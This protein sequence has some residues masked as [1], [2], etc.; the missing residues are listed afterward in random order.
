MLRRLTFPTVVLALALAAPAFAL[1]G[2]Q[3]GP[4]REYLVGFHEMPDAQVGDAYLGGRVVDLDAPLRFLVIETRDAAVFEARARLD[5]NVRYVEANERILGTFL[6]PNDPGYSN[7]GHWGTKKILAQNAWDRTLGATT[8][9]VAVIDSGLLATHEEF[10]G[11]SRVLAGWDTIDEDATP[12]DT[13][14]HGTHVAGTIGATINNNKGIAGLAQVTLYPIRGLTAAL[15]GI[16]CSGSPANLAQGLRRAGDQGMHFSSNSWGGGGSSAITDAINYAHGK[17]VIQVAAAGNS[18]SCTNCVSEPWKANAAKIIVVSSTTS[19]DGFSSFSSQGPEVDVS[20]PGSGIYSSTTGS[21][22]AYT[23]MSGTSMATP[24]VTGVAALVKT[25][26][27][28]WGYTEIDN[29]LKTTAVDLG[30]AGKDDRFGYG[31]INADAATSSAGANDPPTAA[32]THSLSGFTVSVNGASSSDPDGTISSYSWNWGDGTTAGTGSSSSHTYATHGTYTITLTV[33][34]NGGATDTE[35]KTI[36]IADPSDPDATAYTLTNGQTHSNATSGAGSEKH[37]KLQ[38]PT[39]ATQLVVSLD[40]P[41][42][43][44]LVGCN[45]DLDLYTRSG[46]KPTDSTY[47]CRPAEPTDS[48]E[49]CTHASPAAAWWYFRVKQVA[50]STAGYTITATWS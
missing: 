41:D 32:F 12:Q 19:S 25:L 23:S 11:Q 18:G 48:D 5:E 9:K 39:G 4:A 2:A 49:S 46:A 22:G 37:Y 20:A 29:R 6:T 14:G 42:C 15:F 28:T 10:A 16:E 33:T 34:D 40:G 31:R 47:A 50:G 35:A 36:S 45:T 3:D 27:P 8:V 44:P 17:G 7:N 24:H 26:H 21:N 43:V 38:V 30:A 1:P 13:C